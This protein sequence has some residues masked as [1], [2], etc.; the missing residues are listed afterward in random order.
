MCEWRARDGGT[1]LHTAVQEGAD[2]RTVTTLIEL[3]VDVNTVNG[4]L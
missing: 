3:G 2:T 4:E 1:A